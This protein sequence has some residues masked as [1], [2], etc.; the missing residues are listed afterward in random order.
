[1]KHSSIRAKG[2]NGEREIAT[3]LN[4]IIHRVKRRLHYAEEDILNPHKQVQ[5]N[6]MQT[7]IGGCD[8]TNTYTLA[9]E[10]KRQE[11]LSINT[12]W[13]QCAKAAEEMGN[14]IP[15]LLYRQNN[16]KWRA[17]MEVQLPGD[18][19]LYRADLEI[20]SFLDWFEGYLERIL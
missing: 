16:K 19:T 11:Q 20:N 9:I 8:L 10:V 14:Y 7:A 15:V 3:L 17:V 13:K 6:Q 4:P 2:Q 1:M 5:R 18:K 12:W